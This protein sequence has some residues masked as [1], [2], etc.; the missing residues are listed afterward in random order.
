MK[1][2]VVYNIKGGVGKT[3]TAVNLAWLNARR[4]ARTLLWDLD[5]QGA[6]SFYFRVGSQV[7]GSIR[8]LIDGKHDVEARLRETDFESLDLLP[9][10]FALRHLDLLLQ[11][12]KHP[13]RRLA[14]VI[15]PIAAR[16][17]TVIIDSAP[18]ISLVSESLF[19]AAECL[20]LPTI[21]TT[22][23][24]RTLEQLRRH[25]TRLEAR[26]LLL[27]F[28]CMVD[29]RKTMHREIVERWRG[30][31]GFLETEIPYASD[32]ERMGQ[33]RM[34]LGAFASSSEAA[35]AYRALWDEILHRSGSEPTRESADWFWDDGGA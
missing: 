19:H 27:P 30:T 5:P 21:P 28:F 1:T 4:G 34:P 31:D 23:S 18:S 17:D 10:D 7:A 25:L 15:R 29:R 14:R 13:Q 20:V 12:R 6:A 26:P 8:W 3:A 2:F 35:R 24:M 32:V 16:Y 22:L 9:A 33:R 11:D